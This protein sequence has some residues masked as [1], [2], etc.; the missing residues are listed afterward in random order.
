M[1]SRRDFI[2]NSAFLSGSL[3]ILGRVPVFAASESRSSAH[4]G[5]HPFVEQHPE[6]VFIMRTKWTRKTNTEACRQVGL[7]LGRSLFVPMD[8]TGIPVTNNIAAKPNLTGHDSVT[9]KEGITLSGHDGYCYRRVFRRGP[10]R[11][12]D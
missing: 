7:N 12:I 8:S 6:A 2:R 3:G 4:F 11:I 10:V 1:S 9:R 5:V